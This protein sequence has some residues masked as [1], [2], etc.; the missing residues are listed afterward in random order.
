MISDQFAIYEFNILKLQINLSN[1]LPVKIE[2][3]VALYE[4]NKINRAHRNEVLT[5][6]LQS[7]NW[8]EQICRKIMKKQG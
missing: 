6:M 7:F 8:I 4:F 3:K 1:N 5:M 2:L